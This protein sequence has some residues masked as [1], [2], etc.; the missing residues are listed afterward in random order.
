L[1]GEPIQLR[2]GL[3]TGPVVAGVIGHQKFSYD[4]WGD[5]VNVASR[6]ESN[7]VVNKI[8]VTPAVREKLDGLYEFE[9]REPIP[10]KG[11]GMMVTYLLVR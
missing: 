1:H 6:M 9:E 7:G 2:I 11:K 8:Q 4:I 5:V 10:I 3:N